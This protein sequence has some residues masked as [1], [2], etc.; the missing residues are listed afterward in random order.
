MSWLQDR[1]IDIAFENIIKNE[2]K[3]GENTLY[4]GPS[5]SHFIKL[6]LQKD[7]EVQLSKNNVDYKQ[8][9][10]FVVNDC[11]GDL[12]SGEGSHWSLLVY[13]RASNTWYHM[14]SNNGH[15]EPHAKQIIG[16]V[17]NYLVSIGSLLNLRT[18]YIESRCTHQENG[19]D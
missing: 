1:H 10:V 7:I 9:I 14:D 2:R 16:K 15:N 3:N 5:M 8:N 11:K 12:D 19:Y 6:G 13:E 4:F 17:N 18:N